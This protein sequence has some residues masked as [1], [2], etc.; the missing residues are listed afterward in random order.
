MH[1]TDCANRSVELLI[2]RKKEENKVKEAKHMAL[3]QRHLFP[4]GEGFS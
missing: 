4:S 3:F 2:T 1:R